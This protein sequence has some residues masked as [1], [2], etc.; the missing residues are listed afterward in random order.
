MFTNQRLRIVCSLGFLIVSFVGVAQLADSSRDYGMDLTLE[1]EIGE[2]LL[3]A[4]TFSN[5][6]STIVYSS[7]ALSLSLAK[8]DTALASSS[9]VM[10]G[11]GYFYKQEFSEAKTTAETGLKY[12]SNTRYFGCKMMFFKTIAAVYRRQDDFNL[13]IENYQEALKYARTADEKMFTKVNIST[14]YIENEHENLALARPILKEVLSYHLKHPNDLSDKTLNALFEGLSF[15]TINPKKAIQYADS[16]VVYSKKHGVKSVRYVAALGSKARILALNGMHKEAIEIYK[17]GLNIAREINYKHVIL[18]NLKELAE[19]NSRLKQYDTALQYLDSL[20]VYKKKH[21]VKAVGINEVYDMRIN[22]YTQLHDFKQTSFYLRRKLNF[23][24]SIN[25]EKNN[26]AY[27]EFG[28]KYESEIKTKENEILKQNLIITE[29]SIEEEKN[30]RNLFVGISIFAIMLTGYAYFRYRKN[31]KVSKALANKNRTI[32]NQKMALTKTL[33]LS[34]KL[35]KELI[36]ANQAKE[37]LFGVISH[38]LINPF[39]TLLGY[40][41]LL[42]EDYTSFNDE[43]R[44]QF[45]EIIN[46]SALKNYNLTRNLLD[47]SKTQQNKICV[48]KQDLQIV[49]LLKHAADP[50]L[51]FMEKK[52]VR[53]EVHN[54][55][56]T[57]ITDKNLLQTVIGNLVYN[58]IKFSN[59]GGVVKIE[60]TLKEGCK[61][62]EI[63]DE[64]VGM[65]KAFLNNLSYLLFPKISDKSL[66]LIKDFNK[67]LKVFRESGRY[68]TYFKGFRDGYYDE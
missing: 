4:G 21:T 59:R 37:K 17:T 66:R 32:N 12:A 39:N 68:E 28:R 30:A 16:S 38:D 6:D 10:L 8:K 34:E 61:C 53:L 67:Q 3:K 27:L 23:L 14:L 36:E 25:K 2:F 35:N 41:N 64:G 9:Y 7:K 45:L 22:I 26:N 51:A 29:L 62:I 47:W 19:L 46:K 55:F 33:A 52:E 5:L 13:A 44:K 48:Q 65:S 49:A 42:I 11:L 31:L 18:I 40:S 60:V 57:L 56:D 1:G 54:E 24:D 20:E 58:A 15:A 43:E 50:Y 63:I